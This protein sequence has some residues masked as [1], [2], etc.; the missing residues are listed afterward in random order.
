[1]K[2]SSRGFELPAET[3]D[4]IIIGFQQ[5]HEETIVPKKIL[6]RQNNSV[7]APALFVAIMN[8]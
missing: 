6:L 7:L 1:M 5:F 3:N 8:E 2:N 4:I